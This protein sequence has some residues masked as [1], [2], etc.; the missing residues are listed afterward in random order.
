MENLEKTI[1]IAVEKELAYGLFVNRL[2]DWW[3]KAYTWSQD[4]LVEM[5][6]DP[7]VGGL[8]SETGPHGFRCD[9]GRVTDVEENHRIAFTWQISPTRVPQPD[10]DQCSDVTVSFTDGPGKGCTLTLRHAHFDRHGEEGAK[11]A[12]AMAGDKGWPY[13]LQCFREFVDNSW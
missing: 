9:W 10:P 8:C 1:T 5:T 7:Q 2:Y 12:E 13:I 3:P 4:K 6:I 11:Y